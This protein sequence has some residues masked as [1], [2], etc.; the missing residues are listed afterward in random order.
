MKIKDA[1]PL[2]LPFAIMQTELHDEKSA[3]L[4]YDEVSKTFEGEGII[5]NVVT[6]VILTVVDGILAMKCFKGVARK[7]GLNAQRVMQECTSFTYDGKIGYLIPD[8]FVDSKYINEH[9]KRWAERH[10]TKTE[11]GNSDIRVLYRDRNA[12]NT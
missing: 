1:S 7:G 3:S 10:M 11:Y 12:I 4:V 9:Q 8:S 5:D 6:P 2:E